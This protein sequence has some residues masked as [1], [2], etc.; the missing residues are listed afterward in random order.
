MTG[1]LWQG[2][3]EAIRGILGEC[4]EIDQSIPSIQFVDDPSLIAEI[5]KLVDENERGNLLFRGESDRFP[6]VSS[7]LFRFLGLSVGGD[8]CNFETLIAGDRQ[9]LDRVPPSAGIT[10]SAISKLS[11]AQHYSGEQSTP[12]NLID[13][14]SN[15]AIALFFACREEQFRDCDGRIVVIA[16]DR[17][18]HLTD[19]DFAR[20]DDQLVIPSFYDDNRNFDQWSAFLYPANGILDP[21]D[22]CVVSI[23]AT[24]KGKIRDFLRDVCGFSEQSVLSSSQSNFEAQ[25]NARRSVNLYHLGLISEWLGDLK[26]A[27]RLYEH[28][29]GSYLP[30]AILRRFAI[31]CY[32]ESAALPDTRMLHVALSGKATNYR[33]VAVHESRDL[34]SIEKA[35]WLWRAS[36]R[37]GRL[38]NEVYPELGSAWNTPSDRMVLYEMGR[39]KFDKG[40]KDGDGRLV[41]D[42]IRDFRAAVQAYEE[43]ENPNLVPMPFDIC[44]KMA[45]AHLHLGDHQATVAV[46]EQAFE[47]F[48]ATPQAEEARLLLEKAH[49]T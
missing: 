32:E 46:L 21:T 22:Y 16:K 49:R 38:A 42:S 18:P 15:L 43:E 29:E 33:N 45:R 44:V 28:K 23:P 37:F 17:Y 20:A 35:E 27:R 25:S 30:D 1:S 7:S 6:R 26:G 19:V 47:R 31:G 41:E 14:T 24:W 11:H 39:L 10:D 5:S 36:Q 2:D 40:V 48:E 8:F 12:T 3:K 4:H 34:C 9:T 13:L